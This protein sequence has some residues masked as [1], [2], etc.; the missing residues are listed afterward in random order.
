MSSPAHAVDPD[1]IS[2]LDLPLLRVVP[3]DALEVLAVGCGDGALGAALKAIRA[4]R[5]VL[6]VELP[7]AAAQAARGVLDGVFELDVERDAP[8]LSPGSLDALVFDDLLARLRDPEAVLRRFGRFLRPGGTVLCGLP[9][10]QHASVLAMLLRGEFQYQAG[11]ILDLAH[12]RFFTFTSACKMLLDAGFAPSLADATVTPPDETLLQR[13]EPL[14]AQLGVNAARARAFMGCS[15]YV[16]RGMP[17]GW[18]V[19]EARETPMTFVACVSDEAV[20]R[21]NLLASPCFQGDSPHELLLVRGARNAAEG[22]NGG[23]AR[24]QHETV[25]L[26]HQ[27]VYLPRGWPARFARQQALARQRLGEVAV[28]G[29][30]GA[31]FRAAVPGGVEYAGHLLDRERLSRQ[32]ALPAEVDTVDELLIAVRRGTA[33]RFDERLGF[34]FYG[35]DLACAARRAGLKVAVLDAPCFHNSQLGA[36]PPPAFHESGAAFRAKWSA[37]LPIA[38]CCALIR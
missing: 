21:D 3:Y 22:L 23:L 8:E 33:L 5:R 1:A 30:F 15:R 34:H 13:L 7:G 25:V 10:A 6:G 26:V 27:D 35:A 14:V 37:D 29:V 24:A 20:L 9:N 16:M 18:E 36:T 2:G 19:E 4:G 17:L 11:G 38:T 12:L 31:R 32:G 28:A